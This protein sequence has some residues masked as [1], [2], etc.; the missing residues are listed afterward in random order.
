[1]IDNEK[2]V[3]YFYN[4]SNE[5]W[6]Y[7][8]KKMLLTLFAMYASMN[9]AN[10]QATGGFE[11]PSASQLAATTVQEAL[12]L[13][14]EAK[15]VLQ[16]NIVNSLGDE[17]YTFKDATG[18]IVVEIDDEDWHGVKVTP[19]KTVEIIGEVD[20]DANEPTKIDVDAVTVK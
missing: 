2:K 10:A 8:M 11:G 12:D 3:C 17:K 16:G 1:L 15:V 9:I 13:N 5:L 19:E 7:K 6:R 18:E 14:D 4:V 20:K